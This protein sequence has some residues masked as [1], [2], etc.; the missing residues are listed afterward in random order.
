MESLEEVKS[1]SLAEGGG[2]TKGWALCG[3]LASTTRIGLPPD[4]LVRI[5]RGT[6]TEHTPKARNK[7]LRRADTGGAEGWDQS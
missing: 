1:S 3:G 4:S 2:S 6:S 7:K 5:L